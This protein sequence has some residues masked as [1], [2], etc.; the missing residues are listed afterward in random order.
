MISYRL[1]FGVLLLLTFSVAVPVEA[2][3]GRSQ[4][5]PGA[6]RLK[7]GVN[8]KG[9][10]GNANTISPLLQDQG[11]EL[12]RIE[13]QVRTYFVST[14]QCQPVAPDNQVVPRL[15]FDIPQRRS[16]A[17]PMEYKIGLHN[18]TP[19]DAQGRSKIELMTAGGKREILLGITAL[20]A[21]FATVT[22]LS[23]RWEYWVSM[24]ELP[25]SI[26]YQPGKQ[27]CLLRQAKGFIDGS[28][29]LNMAQMLLEAKKYVAARAL[30]GDIQ[31][32]FPE[33]A[34]QTD[35][36]VE[37]WNDAVG[38]RVVDELGVLLENG[39]Y[40][41]AR[42]YARRWPE[43]Q[44]AAVVQVR[45]KA[46]NRQLD[47][48]A[49]RVNNITVSIGS[50]LADIENPSRHREAKGIWNE[51]RNEINANTLPRFGPFELFSLD[52]STSAESRLALAVTGWI[53]GPEDAL[54]DFEAAVGLMNVRHLLV[55][56]L[57]TSPDQSAERTRLVEKI[58]QQEGYSIERVA[59]LLANLPP[60]DSLASE[61]QL[62]ARVVAVDATQSSAGCLMQVPAEYSALRRYPL[63]IAFPRG[64]Q[65]AADAIDWWGGHADRNGFVLVVPQLYAETDSSYGASAA[66]HTQF[67]GLLRTIKA[68][69][70]I[71]DDR[72]FIGGHGIGGEAAMDLAS[73]QPSLFAGVVSLGGRGRRHIQWAAHNSMSMSWYVVIGTLQ[74][75]YYGRMEMLLRRLF[76]RSPETRQYPDVLYTRYRERGFES[77][78]EEVPRLF[79]WMALQKR[80]VPKQIE[81]TILRTTDR[82]WSWLSLEEIPG[83]FACLDAPTN[84]SA[85]PADT[86]G[87]TPGSLSAKMTGNF[88]RLASLPSNGY[89]RLS[90]DLP[91]I[92]LQKP[93]TLR[94]GAK[95]IKVDYEPSVQDLLS[96]FY[97]HRDRSRFCYMKVPFRK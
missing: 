64:G 81:A 52:D 66:E 14:R 76:T 21:Q 23:H 54:D 53:L 83:R 24:S 41:A 72:V 28:K 18:Q 10:C 89:L 39:K 7:N 84:Y 29:Q 92:D 48:N 38:Q 1:Q 58:R 43:E 42:K 15:K 13:Q 85:R 71:D 16:G 35:R 56:Y 95:S 70:S 8:L 61:N 37:D 17:K 87:T 33:L 79:E 93:I 45:A 30:I 20:N 86:P 36:L 68:G 31:S 96:D 34:T 77:F 47:E 5:V 80:Q 19:F 4:D 12:R 67:H 62:Q 59:K 55:D 3:L 73:A 57:L 51:L 9:M 63:M 60:V 44:L 82:D 69:V 27:P 91:D 32:D 75:G 22:S 26:L 40:N 46:I 97:V 90:P 88:F 78:S 65:S 2:Q 74:P 11:L 49:R 94:V 50:I 6:V 25:D